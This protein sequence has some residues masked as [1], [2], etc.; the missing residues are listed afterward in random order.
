[1]R[2]RNADK[3]FWVERVAW[4]QRRLAKFSHHYSDP[5][6][7]V[8]RQSRAGDT[9]FEMLIES[10]LITYS[11]GGSVEEAAA[12]GRRAVCIQFPEIVSKFGTEMPNGI[13]H[14][15]F[16]D[17]TIHVSLLVLCCAK[18]NEARAYFEALDKF[19]LVDAFGGYDFIWNSYR[20]HFCLSPA[21][22]AKTAHWPEAYGDLWLAIRPETAH[23]ERP[24]YLRK[25]LNG[26]YDAMAQELAAGTTAPMS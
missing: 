3:S 13:A 19:D 18:N 11:V 7:S 10:A 1:M 6:E 4:Q 25:F 9:L 21:P 15:G 23:S 20:Q 26:W 5:N 17:I 16:S 22:Q 8:R 14:G 24:G 12:F 2:D